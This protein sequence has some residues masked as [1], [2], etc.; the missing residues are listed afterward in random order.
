MVL[1]FAAALALLFSASPTPPRADLR[2]S[3]CLLASA[4][5][6]SRGAGNFYLYQA[7]SS[8]QVKLQAGDSLE[9]SIYLSP[10]NPEPKGG[11]DILFTDGEN[12]RD[13]GGQA[14][15]DQNGLP[16]HGNTLLRQASGAWYRRRF[17]LSRLA[18]KTTEQWDVVFEGDRYGRYIQFLSDIVIAHAGGGRTVV[19]DGG[20]AEINRTTLNEGYSRYVALV[21]VPLGAATNR[22]ALRRVVSS[23]LRKQARQWT[24]ESIAADISLASQIASLDHSRPKAGREIDAARVELKQLSQH[25]DSKGFR[26][27]EHA[28]ESHLARLRPLTSR[29]TVRLVGHAHIDFQWLWSWQETI[30]V[31]G[32]TFGQAVKFLD[33]VPG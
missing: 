29:Y 8:T 22:S 19:Y 21:P 16:A 28:L 23:A 10:Q 7:F 33:T 25:P 14:I 31:C 3:Q 13:Y 30:R 27:E 11:I 20:P 12:L 5:C 6:L 18:G 17:D 32:D 1:R 24:I 9:Y 15:K 4:T 2:S 26:R